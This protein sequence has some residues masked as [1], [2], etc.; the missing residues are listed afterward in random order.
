MLLTPGIAMQCTAQSVGPVAQS[1]TRAMSN[2]Q[3]GPRDRALPD[4]LG[5]LRPVVPPRGK[6]RIKIRRRSHLIV[7]RGQLL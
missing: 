1:I 2:T 4:E 6:P 5:W 7:A 3:D